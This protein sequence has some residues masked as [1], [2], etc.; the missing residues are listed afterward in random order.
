MGTAV[1]VLIYVKKVA[2]TGVRSCMR[3][4]RT[5]RTGLSANNKYLEHHTTYRSDKQPISIGVEALAHWLLTLLTALLALTI[6]V[7]ALCSR[8]RAFCGF[9]RLQLR[10]IEACDYRRSADHLRQSVRAPVAAHRVH[11]Q[12]CRFFPRRSAPSVAPETASVVRRSR[13]IIAHHSCISG[14][15]GSVLRRAHHPSPNN[16]RDPSHIF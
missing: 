3:Q 4:K 10:H 1:I 6:F 14:R 16:R 15:A 13:S 5:A 7:F 8:Q 12:F 2:T 9:R 11:R